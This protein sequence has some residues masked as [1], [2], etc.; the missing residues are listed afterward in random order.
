MEWLNFVVAVLSSWAPWPG[1]KN[2][3]DPTMVLVDERA[4]FSRSTGTCCMQKQNAH[5]VQLYTEILLVLA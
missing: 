3:V 4:A 2:Q 5:I 1:K